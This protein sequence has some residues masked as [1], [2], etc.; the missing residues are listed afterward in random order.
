MM[1]DHSEIMNQLKDS[2]DLHEKIKAFPQSGGLTYTPNH[3]MTL[4]A[5]P[6]KPKAND[7][8]EES[9]ESWKMKFKRNSCLEDLLVRNVGEVCPVCY[10]NIEERMADGDVAVLCGCT[11]LF[12]L[13]C[14][15][16][17][18]KIAKSK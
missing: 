18:I 12:C 2:F 13:N 15:V 4:Q 8:T 3:C 5:S 11:H 9:L 16:T 10:K 6:G 17:H 14:I 1:E 7:I